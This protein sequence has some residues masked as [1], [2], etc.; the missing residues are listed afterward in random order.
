MKKYF[1]YTM[2]CFTL[3]CAGCS[4]QNNETDSTD[5]EYE[6]VS[7]SSSSEAETS[8]YTSSV[9]TTSTEPSTPA[10]EPFNPADYTTVDFALW[11]HDEIEKGKK[12]TFSGKVLQN[13]KQGEYYLL[14]VAIDSDYNKVVLVGIS[15]S[16]YEKVIAEDDII[17]LYGRNAGLTEYETV[18]GDIRTIPLFRTDHYEVTAY[19][20]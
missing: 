4:N 13:Q 8:E 19:G 11:N 18:R 10:P 20:N 3:L 7:S 2:A 16:L 17:T 14:R 5:E 12:I 15:S 6:Q 9:S 1:L